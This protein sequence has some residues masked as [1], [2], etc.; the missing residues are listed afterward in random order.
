[1]FERFNSQ[2]REAV[3][4]AQEQARD[5]GH[6]YIG[7]EHLLLALIASSGEGVAHQ[8]LNALGVQHERVRADILAIV[9]PGAGAKPGHIPFTPRSK[10]VLELSLREALR[11]RHK[12]ISPEHILLGL[13]RE[14]EGV[15]A[16]ILA[17]EGV[18]FERLRGDLVAR[19]GGEPRG[20]RGRA[21]RTPGDPRFTVG[22]TKGGANVA[23]R[24]VSLAAGGPVGSQ[25]YLLGVL[26]DGESAAARALAA[27]G[28][29]REAVEAKLEEVGT[30]D[31]S[32]EPP[33]AAGARATSLSLEGD[34]VEVRIEAPAIAQQLGAL[35]A[36]QQTDILRG[37]ALPGSERI[38]KT[39]Q[40]VLRDVVRDL[41]TATP[42]EWSPPGWPTTVSVAAY[43]VSSQPSG[44]VP[45]LLVGDGVDEAAVRTWLAESLATQG[46]SQNQNPV[47]FFTVVVGRMGDVVPNAT[48]QDA[49]TV[50]GF[51]SGA[52][53]APT[54]WPRRP[55]A[56]LV[57]LAVED[58]RKAA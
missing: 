32:D 6:D 29:T 46:P 47:A 17:K 24:A 41:E 57:A 8:M 33:E 30:V 38:W 14:G 37:A 56:E 5:L 2:A 21:F 54:E 16:Q 53:P 7:T 11:L 48:D 15:A 1:M 40:P 12:T 50:T 18:D 20:R 49:W 4:S 58:L 34:T 43:A 27:L 10:K 36:Q 26:D 44:P 19:L 51:Q 3:I 52:N 23:N 35:L 13:I 28:V 22:M 9:G 39:L 45:R 42:T 31:T 55:L 25:H